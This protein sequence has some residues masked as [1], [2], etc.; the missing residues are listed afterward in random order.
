ME[1][2]V[3]SLDDVP[4]ERQRWCVPVSQRH[5]AWDT[6]D[7]GQLTRLWED[8]E[9][10]AEDFLSGGIAY[11]HY[12]GA[13]IVAEPPNQAFGTVRQRLLVD[14]QQ[15]ITTFQLLLIAIRE[16]AR[17]QELEELI[18]V[19]DAY[20]FNEVSGGMSQPHVERYKLWPSSFDRKLYRQIADNPKDEMTVLY[21]DSF[22]KNG[23]LK[24]TFAARLLTAYW[25]FVEAIK[26]F[27]TDGGVEEPATETRLKAILSGFLAGFR[28]VVI[29]LD[30]KDD[31]QEIFA[32]LNGLGKPLTA[33]DLI[34][35]DVFYRARQAGEDDERFSKDSGALLKIRSG[36]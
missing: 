5:Y 32:S 9:E 16:V 25:Y 24:T 11:P 3:L 2:R 33:I 26:E 23:R 17:D 13:I 30:D 21:R 19:V 15:R 27:V 22:F 34:R 31:A 18:P 35:N 1:A 12:I 8:I 4:R 29:Q 20:L 14:G 28:V 36:M 7:D 6:G 10:K